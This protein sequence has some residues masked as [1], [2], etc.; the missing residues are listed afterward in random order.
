MVAL[1]GTTACR[2]QLATLGANGL[3]H[4]SRR[5]ADVAPPADY[6]SVR[7]AG[8]GV[9]LHGWRVASR[10]SLRR[11]TFVYLHG[12]ADSRRSAVG[13]MERFANRGF[14]A[15][16]YDSRAHGDSE[17]AACT[18][19]FYEKRDLSRVLDQIEAG[20]IVVM[21]TS[22]GAAVALQAAADDPR[23]GA[24]I[25]AE[26]FADLRSV[27]SAR[28]PWFFG[29]GVVSRAFTLAEQMGNFR[30]DDVSP[31]EAARRIKAPVFVI[32]GG[33]DTETPPE[34]SRRIFNALAA[35]R[36]LRIVEGAGHNRS[37]TP[38]VWLEIDAWIDSIL[39]SGTPS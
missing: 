16:A 12:V 14:D 20:P 31:V 35:P 19:G 23:I 6:K 39:P 9:A 5:P 21:G 37:L 3:L 7:F 11:G 28:A 10:T 22:L 18:Y 25:A 1:I 24:V 33:A 13:A 27:A 15:V 4:P 2:G 32:H 29:D 34:H 30:V 8:A 26:S 36:Q 38:A 17:G